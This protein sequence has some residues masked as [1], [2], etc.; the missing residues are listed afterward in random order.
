M[1]DSNG[2]EKNFLLK[3]RRLHDGYSKIDSILVWR[4]KKG[5]DHE[6]LL[7]EISKR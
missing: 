5:G 1:E 2:E 6:E 3:A 4:H 7:G